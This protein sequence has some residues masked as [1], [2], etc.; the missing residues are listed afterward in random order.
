MLDCVLNNHCSSSQQY[1]QLILK[2]QSLRRTS[3]LFSLRPPWGDHNSSR[4]WGVRLTTI[5]TRLTATTVRRMPNYNGLHNYL[6]SQFSFLRNFCTY[7]ELKIEF[8]VKP[9]PVSFSRW[10][11]RHL[12]QPWMPSPPLSPLVFFFGRVLYSLKAKVSFII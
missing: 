4:M 6:S 5:E 2:K 10:G 11:Y 12:H 7:K 1:Y 8:I 3:M 9:F